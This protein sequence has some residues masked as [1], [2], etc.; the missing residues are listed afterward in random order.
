M[1]GLGFLGSLS[2]L[3]GEQSNDRNLR[4]GG[5][6]KVLALLLRAAIFSLTGHP[7]LRVANHSRSFQ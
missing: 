1:V 4:A 7:S 6:Q 3:Q 2:R 5:R